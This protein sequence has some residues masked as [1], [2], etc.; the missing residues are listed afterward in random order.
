MKKLVEVNDEVSAVFQGQ[1][2]NSAIRVNAFMLDLCY[3]FA[4]DVTVSGCYTLLV[5]LIVYG[6]ILVE[7]FY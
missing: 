7:C 1:A 4:I 6:R 3:I 5:T 2:H